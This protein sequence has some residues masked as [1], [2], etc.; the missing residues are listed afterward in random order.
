MFDYQLFIGFPKDPIFQQEL[1]KANDHLM[2][3]FIN[4]HGEYL[5]EINHQGMQYL[6]KKVGKLATFSDITLIEANIYS[7]L[8]KL[9]PHF[10]YEETPLM[11][12][13]ISESIHAK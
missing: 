13:P 9:V 10:P 7:I 4:T 2:N 11:L 8:K 1:Q 3:Q 6:G 5:Q 12:F